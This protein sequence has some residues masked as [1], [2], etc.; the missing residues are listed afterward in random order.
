LTGNYFSASLIGLILLFNND[1]NSYELELI[2]LGLFLS[3]LFVG[4]IYAFSK[5][6]HL[7][8]AAL[9]TVSSRLSVFVPIVL[10]IIFYN[11]IPNQYQYFGLF[12]TLVTII[13]FY[14]SVG[15]KIEIAENRKK[16]IYLLAIL[17]GIGIA[18]FFMKVFQ[19]NWTSYDKPWFLIWIFF[20][21][22]LI[23][24][25]ISLRQRKVLNKLSLFLGIIMGIPNIFSSYFLIDALKEFSAVL[26]YPVVNL[27]II[28]GTAI[29][30]KI[31][32]NEE[33][34]I[35][36][37]FALLTGILAIVLLSL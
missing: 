13:L 19:E 28:V 24:L 31:V 32:W 33:W 25:L 3:F 15:R 29:I 12:L 22:F 34:N 18:D 1:K 27:S 8:G 11:E 35:Y 16:F 17:L 26:V 10:S 6:V 7:S 37:K 5:S 36:A 4:S 30:V 21:A 23:T 14:Y 20:F 2:P 9:S